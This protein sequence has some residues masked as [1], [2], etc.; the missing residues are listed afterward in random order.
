MKAAADDGTGG[1]FM[2]SH[3]SADCYIH[4]IFLLAKDW[5]MEQT[6]ERMRRD[7]EADERVYEERL[8]EAR[9]RE[10][11]MRRMAKARVVKKAVRSGIFRPLTFSERN[12]G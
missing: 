1:K 4:S 11:A 10:E 3:P 7:L 8:A 12:S 9:R 2:Y 6:M 5:V